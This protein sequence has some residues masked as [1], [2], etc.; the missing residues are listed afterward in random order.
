[1]NRYKRMINEKGWIYFINRIH[2]YFPLKWLTDVPIMKANNEW[3]L[4]YKYKYKYSSVLTRTQHNSDITHQN[5]SSKDF[6]IWTLWLQGEANAPLMVKKCLSQMR[7]FYGDSRLVVLDE[8]SINQ[9][10]DLPRFIKEKYEKGFI[11]RAHYSD[12]IR[13]FLLCDYG[14]IWIDSTCLMT[15]K[16]PDDVFNSRFFVFRLPI[17]FSGAIKASNWFILS[18]KN[19]TIMQLIKT[20]LM[21]Y[22]KNHKHIEDYLLFHIFFSIAVDATEASKKEWSA[23]PYYNNDN[24]HILQREILYPFNRERYEN[25]CRISC[26]HKLSWKIKCPNTDSFYNYIISHF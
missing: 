1:M 20:M 25:I 13:V 18:E 8:E 2:V 6:K 9:Y 5:R 4:Y 15:S 12:I 3:R 22:W 11:S 19:S 24:T 21:E 14:G 17:C 10:V 16:L 26:I 7:K 23:M